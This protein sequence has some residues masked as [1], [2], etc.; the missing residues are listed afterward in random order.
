MDYNNFYDTVKG[1]APDCR[2]DAIP[3]WRDFAAECV[4]KGQFVHFEFT[5]D[6]ASAVG[7]WLDALSAGFRVVNESFGQETAA[8][9]VNLSC[10]RCCLYPV[11]MMQAAVLMKNGSGSKQILLKIESGE[12]DCPNLFEAMPCENQAVSASAYPNDST[13]PEHSRQH[14]QSSNSHGRDCE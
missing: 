5:T 12:I 14:G 2:E 8:A 11:E 6:T 13:K 9:V 4:D 7:K 1:L 3:L 10:E